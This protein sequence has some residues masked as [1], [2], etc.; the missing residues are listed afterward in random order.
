M[1]YFCTL[2]LETDLISL[3]I[4]GCSWIW[5]CMTL[6][7][8]VYSGFE[9]HELALHSSGKHT[10]YDTLVEI[11][12]PFQL[13]LLSSIWAQL[14]AM[15]FMEGEALISKY[16]REGISC[17]VDVFSIPNSSFHD[18]RKSLYLWAWS[19]IVASIWWA[20]HFTK[21]GVKS[22][23]HIVSHPDFDFMI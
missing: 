6:P 19:V 3:L 12:S 11:L 13:Q 16:L 18:D 21:S 9:S 1:K 23:Q 10:Y 5:Y 4:S 17:P 14:F 2:A 7:D 22:S 15:I 20:M 8:L